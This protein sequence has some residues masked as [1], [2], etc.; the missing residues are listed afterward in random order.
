MAQIVRR[1]CDV[2]MTLNPATMSDADQV[3]PFAFGGKEYD[4]DVCDQC[5]D[6][7]K[8]EFMWWAQFA[9][10]HGT[11]GKMV[12]A[13]KAADASTDDQ[14]LAG[15]WWRAPKGATPED[16]RWYSDLRQRIREWAM[17]H[18]F[19]SL[20]DRGKLPGAAL[21]AWARAHRDEVPKVKNRH[22]T[23]EP[24]DETEDEAEQD[25]DDGQSTLGIVPHF[26]DHK[27]STR[28]TPGKKPAAG[29]RASAPVRAAS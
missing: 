16:Q 20:G 29:K 5:A 23:P 12:P 17:G 19:P 27:P 9:R 1:V 21:V 24:E 8:E 3:V 25:S 10:K 4:L 18:G 11:V 26:S 22:R 7:I 6:E 15:E 14:L 2:H 28:K 13:R